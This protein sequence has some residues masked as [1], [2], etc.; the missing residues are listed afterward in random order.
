MSQI[1]NIVVLFHDGCIFDNKLRLLSK[2]LCVYLRFALDLR[3]F[4]EWLL[5][6]RRRPPVLRCCFLPERRLFLEPPTLFDIIPVCTEPAFVAV[7]VTFANTLLAELNSL[8]ESVEDI[9]YIVEKI[10]T[11][12]TLNQRRIQSTQRLI[13]VIINNFH[14][15]AL[16][17]KYAL[18]FHFYL[19]PSSV[20]IF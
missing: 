15:R 5:L 19:Q 16:I 17:W 4:F 9:I 6:E 7:G 12:V 2:K 20:S 8:N 18:P 11:G 14:T 1:C 13:E 10:Y 3:F